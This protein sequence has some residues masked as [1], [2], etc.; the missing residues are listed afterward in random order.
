MVKKKISVV[1]AAFNEEKNVTSLT[2]RI[3]K[4]IEK[5]FN[6]EIIYVVAG[7][8]GTQKTLS[9]LKNK[10]IKILYSKKALGLGYDFKKGFKEISKDT[11]YVLTMDADLNHQPEEILN[12]TKVID[13][14]DVVIGSRHV[15]GGSR[16]NIPVFKKVVSDFT[17]L[18]FTLFFGVKIRDKTS[19]YRMYKKKAIDYLYKRY[20]SKNFEFLLE[21][22]LIAKKAKMKM[23]E[24]P[25]TFI[26]RIHGTSK[27]HLIKTGI[28][29]LKLLLKINFR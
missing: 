26:Y 4:T 20:K 25:I 15:S 19:G 11:D 22:L 12:F 24:V 7:N 18:F 23:T 29:Y 16:K 9:N 2:K 27:F 6:Y 14:Y 28:G 13:K 1:I 21:L 3:I 5:K 8:D 17:N 10:K